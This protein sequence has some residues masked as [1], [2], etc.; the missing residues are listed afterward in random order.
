MEKTC[1]TC[2]SVCLTKYPV[3]DG[4]HN[5]YECRHYLSRWDTVAPDYWC[6]LHPAHHVRLYAPGKPAEIWVD[7][8]WRK[9]GDRSREEKEEK[10]DQLLEVMESF[11]KPD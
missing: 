4:V 1:K 11:D 6:T 9:C 8:A 2:P 5:A 7:G 3:S 10:V